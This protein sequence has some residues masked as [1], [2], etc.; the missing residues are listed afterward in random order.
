MQMGSFR[1]NSLLKNPIINTT[2]CAPQLRTCQTAPYRGFGIIP[3]YLLLPFIFLKKLFQHF[4]ETVF[5]WLVFFFTFRFIHF[6]LLS[7]Q[8][9]VWLIILKWAKT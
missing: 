9:R 1:G 4:F 3:D 6:V 8:V 5:M 2:F 7:K